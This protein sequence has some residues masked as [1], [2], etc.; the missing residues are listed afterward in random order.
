MKKKWKNKGVGG[1]QERGGLKGGERGATNKS[2]IKR[3]L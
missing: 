1:G 2:K 3:R